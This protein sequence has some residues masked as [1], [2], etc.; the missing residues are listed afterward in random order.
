MRFPHLLLLNPASKKI[1][2]VFVIDIQA[3]IIGQYSDF[4][5]L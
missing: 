3:F 1:I 2:P 4:A 5:G